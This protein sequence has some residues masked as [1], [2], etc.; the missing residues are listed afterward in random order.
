LV[1]KEKLDFSKVSNVRKGQ[2]LGHF[3]QRLEALRKYYNDPNFC[4][5]CGQIIEVGEDQQPCNVKK[6]DNCSNRC[7][8]TKYGLGNENGT[9]K[10][11]CPECDGTKSR[12]AEMCQE[13]RFNKYVEEY[14]KQT[15]KEAE[16]DARGRVKFNKVRRMARRRLELDGRVSKECCICGFSRKVEVAHLKP[17][18]EFDPGDSVKEVN[19]RSNLRYLCPN[20][21]AVQE[22][23]SLNNEEENKI[24]KNWPY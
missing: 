8:A 6:L 4:D 22:E 19:H 18:K 5:T 11:P 1:R 7:S 20:H 12:E 10:V 16:S 2:I 17:I 9:H 15:L 24:H 3:S 23:G 14:E 21:H 13:C